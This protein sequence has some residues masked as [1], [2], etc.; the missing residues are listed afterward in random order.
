M[1][2]IIQSRR[3]S[4]LTLKTESNK[5]RSL[6]FIVFLFF[7]FS[8]EAEPL[9]I[10]NAGSLPVSLSNPDGA[11]ISLS[12]I[13]SA[14]LVLEGDVRFFRGI[15]LEFTA[16]QT[17]L[18]HRGSL[19]L[20]LYADLSAVPEPG[21]AD[22]EG[23]QISFEPAPNKIQTIYQ[24]PL[25]RDHGL[26]PTPYAAVPTGV[27]APSSFPII[28]RVLPV[29][30]GLS[31]E[32]ETMRFQLSAKPLFSNE[33]AVKVSPRY[34]EQLAGRPFTLLI[35]D[36]VVENPGEERLLKEGE[37]T[38]VIVSNDYRNESRSF[39]IER[40]KILDLPI[41]L[42]D[43]TP[44]VIFEGPEN[45]RIFF[46]NEPVENLQ[47]PYPAEPGPHEVR[48]QLSDYSVIKTLNIQKGKTYRVALAV[49]VDVSESD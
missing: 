21:V 28:F 49:D 48:F 19:A 14:V 43:P 42:Q 11:S 38:L 27:V 4:A 23:R 30:K 1:T 10:M 9:R 25:R 2:G 44:L 22:I 41:A 37:H 24:I 29:I 12:Y 16:P 39:M 40:G 26:R 34:P 5:K 20:A 7:S 8:L 32:I 47:T 46:D 6:L 35:D 3:F 31:E 33:G 13:D 18:A 45:A 15:E 36:A 17:Y